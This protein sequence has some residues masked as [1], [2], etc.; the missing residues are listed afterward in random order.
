MSKNSKYKNYKIDCK[1]LLYTPSYKCTVC[2]N[3]KP[4]SN[5]SSKHV[6]RPHTTVYMYCNFCKK[7]TK[8]VL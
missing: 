4:I 7:K 5:I 8:M 6:G 2:G 3:Y 1:H